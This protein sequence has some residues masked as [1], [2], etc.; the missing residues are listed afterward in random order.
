MDFGG[1]LIAE[2]KYMFFVSDALTSRCSSNSKLVTVT[3]NREWFE[4][5][6]GVEAP[7]GN[8]DAAACAKAE[9]Q[10]DAPYC[11]EHS[12]LTGLCTI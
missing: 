11:R 4:E 3:L 8:V 7:I 1:S 12:E 5:N 9:L 10:N 2:R 6:D